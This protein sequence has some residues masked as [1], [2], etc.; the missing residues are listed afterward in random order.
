MREISIKAYAKINLCLDVLGKQSNGYHQVEMV[1][2]EVDLFDVVKV[3]SMQRICNDKGDNVEQGLIVL[4]TNRKDLPIGEGNLAYK[5]AKL[6][7]K[8]YKKNCEI[9]IDL[10]K[11]IP[12]S[13]GMAGG[14]ANGAAVLLALSQLWN[15]N[16]TLEE[17]MKLGE[18][19]GADVPFCIMGQVKRMENLQLRGKEMASTCALAQGIGEKLTP[20]PALNCLV[21]LSKPPIGV[22]TVAVYNGLQM[23]KIN[24]HPDTK[25]LI[26]GLKEHNFMKIQRNMINVLE[27]V[28]LRDFPVVEEMKQQIQN[29]GTA[30]AVLMS[31][32]GPTIFALYTNQEKAKAA[33]TYMKKKSLETYLVRTLS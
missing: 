19:L 16:L 18:T 17:L 9:H 29:L 25:E 12:I 10:Q 23:E 32:S 6:M 28:T 21:L 3:H 24:R 1:M 27:A 5:A 4:T 31:G 20:L 14:S 22:S 8:T 26:L 2:Q 33:Y 13:A 15:L 30:Y 11:Q 7:Q